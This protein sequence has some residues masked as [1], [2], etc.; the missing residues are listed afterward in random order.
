MTES[1]DVVIVGAGSAGCVLANRLT[2]DPHLRVLLLEAGGWDWNP[3]IS[4]PPGARKLSQYGLYDWKDLSEPDPGLNGRRMAIPHGKVIGGGSST[5][6]L[7]HTRGHPADYDRW[8]E[9]GAVGWS[10]EEVLPHFKACETWEG[11]ANPWR[12]GDGELGAREA[13]LEDPIFK[14]WFAAARSLGYEIT[15]DYNGQTPEGFG[16]A[17]YSLRN[18]RR[19]SSAEA[20]LRPALKR[21][22][23]TVRTGALATRVLF[24]G[25]RARGVE[26]VTRGRRQQVIA[27]QRTVLCLGAINTPHLLMLSGVGPADHLKTMGISPIVD[28]PVG[29]NLEDHLGIATFWTRPE[30][31][32]FNRSL[33]FDRMA[34]NMLR[35]YLLRTGPASQL[36]GVILAFLKSNPAFAQPDLELIINLAPFGAD[37]WF[38]GL[39]PAYEDGFGIRTQLVSQESRG[40]VLLRT[41][42]PNDRPVVFYNSLSAQQDLEVLREGYKR[43]WA[44]GSAP[45]LSEFRGEPSFP[46][47]ELKTDREI[48]AFI[49][50]TAIQLYHPACTCR[51]GAGPDAV[52]EPDLSVRGVEALN[53]VD[54]SAMPRLVTANPNVPIMMMAAKAAAMWRGN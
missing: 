22:N 19:S 12:G 32:S 54:A 30:P 18:G 16:P 17:Q 8:V 20:F 33:R 1:F 50:Q 34:T 38:P 28:L 9:Q 3:L 41:A 31:G 35:A 4:I 14:A 23:L 48:D 5:N 25:R 27:A 21:P 29:K 42:D 44:L 11:G 6:F 37:L 40:E 36:P 2:Q 45:E 15:P 24:E 52:L 39:K 53:I 49:R 13:P 26:Y 10:Y 47:R 46:T 51:M 43:T 7:A